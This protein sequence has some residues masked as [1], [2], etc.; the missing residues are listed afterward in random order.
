MLEVQLGGKSTDKKFFSALH[1]RLRNNKKISDVKLI[2]LR[3][4]GCNS[5][6][7]TF[8]VSFVF[9]GSE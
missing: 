2:D 8:S 6:E 7:V 5:R 1:D 3:D 4:A 9:K